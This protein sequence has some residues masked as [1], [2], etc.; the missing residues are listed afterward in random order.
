MN[1]PMNLSNLLP[2]VAVEMKRARPWL[3]TL[4]EIS[5]TGV[6]ATQA[7]AAIEQA[8]AAV[9]KV[10]ALMSYHDAD[11][12]VSRINRNAF[13]TDV[14]V[15]PHTFRV[16]RAAQLM[17]Q[18]SDGLFDITVVP[19]LTRLG[20]LPR[21]ENCP[22]LSSRGR[23]RDMILLSGNRVRFAC[24]LNIDLSGIAKGYAVDVA[25]KA[26]ADA[27]MLAGRV[28]AGGD[29]RVFGEIAQRISVR[30][31]DAHTQ[32]M[33]LL[34]V[35]R[36]A[37]AT[38]A[39]YYNSRLHCGRRVMPIIQ[40]KTRLACGSTRSVT[41][42]ARDCMTADALTKVVHANTSGALAVLKQYQA[43]AFIIENNPLTKS[44]HVFDTALNKTSVWGRDE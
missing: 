21:L 25:I 29:L 43:R 31:P 22:S 2:A 33:P 9:G 11:S 19:V 16:L 35:S 18:A 15:D 44:C 42:L 41:V 40:P 3:G 30:D 14:E 6:D 26:L 34:N 37:V 1:A 8:Y 13:N 28:N 12:D 20:F 36:G 27:G 17:A 24:G 38:S 23:W 4:V 32:T 5:A 39:G 10:H 7:L